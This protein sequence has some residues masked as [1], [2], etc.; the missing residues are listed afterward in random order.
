MQVRSTELK[1]IQ[2]EML[3]ELESLEFDQRDR[4]ILINKLYNTTIKTMSVIST[5]P[6]HAPR[7]PLREAARQEIASAAKALD[8]FVD[9][10]TA[11]K[12]RENA[13]RRARLRK[14]YC[15]K[16]RST[17]GTVRI[18]FPQTLCTAGAGMTGVYN[19]VINRR[20]PAGRR[21]SGESRRDTGWVLP[22]V[23]RHRPL[24][25]PALPGPAP[26]VQLHA[27]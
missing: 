22:R 24:R 9:D 8:A 1:R 23:Q 20:L 4:Q 7:G 14:P 12:A 6:K 15:F 16:M 18:L 2:N 19:V 25:R 5:K 10:S 27:H 21:V 26:A 11:R 17:P 3:Q 13:E